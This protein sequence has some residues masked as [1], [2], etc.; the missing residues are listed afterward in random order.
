MLKVYRP[1]VEFP[2][3]TSTEPTAGNPH[4]VTLQD[5]LDRADYPVRSV[6]INQRQSTVM[7]HMFPA[8]APSN[9]GHLPDTFAEMLDDGLTNIAVEMHADRHD[10]E[11]RVSESTGQ[12]SFREKYGDRIADGILLVDASSSNDLLPPFYQESGGKQK[13]ESERVIL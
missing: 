3:V 11:T 5:R 2:Q 6:V 12:K 10:R 4:P 8:L 1:F 9:Q 13:G 7:Y